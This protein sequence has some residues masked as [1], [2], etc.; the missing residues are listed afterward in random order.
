MEK[1]EISVAERFNTN[2][3]FHSYLHSFSFINFSLNFH[4]SNKKDVNTNSLYS[5]PFILEGITDV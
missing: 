5:L 3:S 2:S 1:S 4:L